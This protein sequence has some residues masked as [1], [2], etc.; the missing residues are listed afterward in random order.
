MPS[1]SLNF[2]RVFGYAF[3]GDYLEVVALFRQH[4]T[5]DTLSDVLRFLTTSLCFRTAGACPENNRVGEGRA[6]FTRAEFQPTGNIS[7]YS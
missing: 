6:V 7:D 4:I 5:Y 1:K 3:K 2:T